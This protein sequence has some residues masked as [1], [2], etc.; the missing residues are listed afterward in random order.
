[1][2]LGFLTA[3]R[4][5]PIDRLVLSINASEAIKAQPISL[6]S[7]ATWHA[8]R[9]RNRFVSFLARALVL[10]IYPWY[11]VAWGALRSDVI[12]A[13]TNPFWLPILALWTKPLHGKP[14]V[15]AVY[16]V[17]PDAIGSARL[18]VL[19]MRGLMNAIARHWMKSSDAVVFIAESMRQE[20]VKRFGPPRVDRVIVTGVN[21]E[22]FAA[23]VHQPD[24]AEWLGDRILLS[25]VGN[26]GHVHDVETMGRA[27]KRLVSALPDR[28]AIYFS[29]SGAKAALLT[30]SVAHLDQVWVDD[31]SLS[32]ERWAWV[33]ART[34]IALITL[35]DV[36]PTASMPSKYFSALGAG[37]VVAVVAP[38]STDLFTLTV[39]HG[40]GIA[41]PPGSH[42]EFAERLAALVVNRAEMAEMTHRALSLA[43]DEYDLR[44]TSA[45]WIKLAS[46]VAASK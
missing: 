41:V 33:L 20:L 17:Y 25:Y 29:T 24:I 35:S 18:P 42:D 5:G 32:D 3:V 28:V 12:V 22:E 34:D 15:T 27:L 26:A 44:V 16:D 21:V 14:I 23:P 10:L 37:C 31:P 9:G 45:E 4:G 19:G 30:S 43:R 2:R 46:E 6:F 7:T 11:G 13:T 38:L 39:G 1:V 36:T 8:L 40:V